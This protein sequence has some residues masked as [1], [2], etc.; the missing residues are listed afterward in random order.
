VRPADR[1]GLDRFAAQQPAASLDRLLVPR[2]LSH[3]HHVYG[4][5]LADGSFGE[6]EISVI[7][8]PGAQQVLDA[9]YWWAGYPKGPRLGRIG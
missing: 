7:T 2:A 8:V 1:E 3:R 6:V 5:T 4:D 9:F